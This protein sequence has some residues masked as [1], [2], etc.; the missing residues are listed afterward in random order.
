MLLTL[1]ALGGAYGQSYWQKREDLSCEKRGPPKMHLRAL[2]LPGTAAGLLWCSGNFF[3]TAAVVRGGNVGPLERASFGRSGGDVAS[4][5]SNPAGDLGSFRTALLS[6][7]PACVTHGRWHRLEVPN[8]RSAICWCF[9]A[10][11]TLSFILLLSQASIFGVPAVV[12]APSFRSHGLN[13][14]ESR[15]A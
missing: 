6:R 4:E 2:L 7:G 10:L 1:L 11:W 8:C 14:D 13:G 12:S 9:L 3:Q 15:I 5:S